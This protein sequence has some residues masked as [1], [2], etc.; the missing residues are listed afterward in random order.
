MKRLGTFLSLSVADKRLLIEALAALLTAR[1]ALHVWKLERLRAWAGRMGPKGRPVGRVVWAAQAAAHGVPGMSCLA[2][3]LAVQRL[4]ARHGHAA[5]VH[6][7]VA[8]ER[9]A[10]TAHAWVVHDG[11]VLVDTQDH[12]AYTRL[13]VWPAVE[14]AEP[15]RAKARRT[16]V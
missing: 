9:Q 15:R 3:A 2:S 5:E 1:L 8:R 11:R 14:E 6:I 13:V 10:F 16:P 7:G 4:L 12:G